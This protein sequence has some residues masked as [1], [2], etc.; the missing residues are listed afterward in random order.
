MNTYKTLQVLLLGS[1]LLNV[2]A[3]SADDR[4]DPGRRE[5]RT[6][7]AACHG[8]EGKGDG[9]LAASLN[10]APTNLTLLAKSNGGV[11]P[12]QRVQQVIDGR[13]E[14]KP[15][16]SREMPIWG[17]RFTNQGNSEYFDVPF[18]PD[19]YVAARILVLSEYLNR[20]QAK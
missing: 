11:F 18:N 9:P 3:A 19:A 2:G 13:A 10:K 1:A 6:S 4:K 16:G 8:P 7:C 17:E 20:I 5:Y 15:H 14:V 12:A